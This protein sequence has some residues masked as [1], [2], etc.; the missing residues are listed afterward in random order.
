MKREPHQLR[1]H[2]PQSKELPKFAV[3]IIW[4]MSFIREE[5]TKKVWELDAKKVGGKLIKGSQDFRHVKT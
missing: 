1:M 4:N 5:A 2:C 3:S